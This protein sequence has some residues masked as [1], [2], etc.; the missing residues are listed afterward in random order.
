VV[1]D[2]AEYPMNPSWLIG[3]RA[4]HHAHGAQGTVVPDARPPL[5]SP[6]NGNAADNSPEDAAPDQ[7]RAGR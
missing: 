4:S 7:H 2:P 6:V 1:F 5:A 3:T